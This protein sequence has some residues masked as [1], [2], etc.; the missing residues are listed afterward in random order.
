[1][2]K[3]YSSYITRSHCRLC[4]YC[5]QRNS[6]WRKLF[7]N[8]IREAL[9]PVTWSVG[10]WPGSRC[11]TVVQAVSPGRRRVTTK[12]RT[13]LHDWAYERWTEWTCVSVSKWINVRWGG[14]LT[15]VTNYIR[16]MSS[17]TSSV[18][19]IATA[20]AAGGRH[21]KSA[22]QSQTD[23]LS[24]PRLYAINCHATEG[25]SLMGRY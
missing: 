23:R 16:R 24:W 19:T 2:I 21:C 14:H 3:E 13:V 18:V 22:N 12:A 4:L 15:T 11:V 7:E 1:M 20:A 9:H 25:L 6:N 5:W 8:W 17:L 10:A